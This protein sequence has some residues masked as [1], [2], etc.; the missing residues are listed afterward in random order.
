M[1]ETDPVCTVSMRR[2]LFSYWAN[3]RRARHS[4]SRCWLAI[5]STIPSYQLRDFGRQM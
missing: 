2:L 5:R 1:L 4:G 3:G